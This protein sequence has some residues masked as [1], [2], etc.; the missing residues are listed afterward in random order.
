MGEHKLKFGKRSIPLRTSP[1]LI[2]TG[3]KVHDEALLTLN[4]SHP[5]IVSPFDV[6]TD[7]ILGEYAVYPEI[8]DQILTDA[9]NSTLSND[10]LKRVSLQLLEFLSFL[11]NRGW[12]YNDFKP[13]HFL[14]GQQL[15]V[16]DFGLCEQI[17]GPKTS[18]CFSGTFPYI[19]PEKFTGKPYD[20]RSDFFSLGMMM[21]RCLLPEENWDLPPSFSSLMKL[22]GN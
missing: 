2:K 14:I 7:E 1:C 20:H 22:Q 17:N 15:H 19:S 11:H 21:L 13:E 6:G 9:L 18:S 5:F 16:V 12:L 4:L 8:Q 3:S 10:E